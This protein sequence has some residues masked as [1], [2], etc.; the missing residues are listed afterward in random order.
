MWKLTKDTPESPW[1]YSNDA[2]VHAV[3][4]IQELGILYA[5]GANPQVD[6]CSCQVPFSEEAAAVR[7]GSFSRIAEIAGRSKAR[8]LDNGLEECADELRLLRITELT[9]ARVLEVLRPLTYP[10]AQFTQL[11]ELVPIVEIRDE[12]PSADQ[13]PTILSRPMPG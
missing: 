3:F 13:D 4:E 1:V 2:R 12:D 5:V 8:M 6:H 11:G 10:E 7:F 9:S